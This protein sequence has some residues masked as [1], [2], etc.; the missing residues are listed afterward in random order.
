MVKLFQ[1]CTFTLALIT[2]VLGLYLA[3]SGDILNGCL[4]LITVAI[5]SVF[6][7]SVDN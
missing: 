2:A 1:F 3:A 4:T 6:I 5:L 7:A